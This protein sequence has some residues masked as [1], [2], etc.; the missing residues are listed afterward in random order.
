M[1]WR[2]D[3]VH[4]EKRTLVVS[5]SGDDCVAFRVM[6]RAVKSLCVIEYHKQ[7][8]YSSN[9]QDAKYKKQKQNWHCWLKC[10]S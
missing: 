4:G 5:A 1:M 3:G 6:K 9:K 8:L 2:S 10:C 7:V